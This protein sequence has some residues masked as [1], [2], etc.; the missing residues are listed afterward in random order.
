ARDEI[1]AL[2]TQAA[3]D[4]ADVARL[5][6]ALGAAFAQSAALEREPEM[7]QSAAFKKRLA[8]AEAARATAER[9]ALNVMRES[10]VFEEQLAT[11]REE[12]R[13]MREQ[14][15]ANA[16]NGATTAHELAELRR[17]VEVGKARSLTSLM[18]VTTQLETRISEM[19]ELGTIA[20]AR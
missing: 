1:R 12:I 3:Q 17:E 13:S 11:A 18:T 9:A 14:M 10:K 6:T 16:V 8:E 20:S 15:T 4:A 5:R 19:S 2:Q 7:V